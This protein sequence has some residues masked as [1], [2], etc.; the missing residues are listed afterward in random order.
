MSSRLSRPLL[1]VP[2]SVFLSSFPLVSA[3]IF[4]ILESCKVLVSLSLRISSICCSR[5]LSSPWTLFMSSDNCLPDRTQTNPGSQQQEHKATRHAMSV[6]CHPKVACTD[7]ND[8]CQCRNQVSITKGLGCLEKY[9]S[10]IVRVL[11]PWPVLSWA[12]WNISKLSLLLVYSMLCLFSGWSFGD[13]L[14][15][16][17]IYP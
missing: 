5:S 3:S 15:R 7:Y 6:N 1:S 8:N 10:D 4:S 17:L 14:S 12:G 13:G 16:L 2:G 11:V 9:N